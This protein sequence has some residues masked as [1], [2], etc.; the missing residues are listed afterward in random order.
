VVKEPAV[1]FVSAARAGS[2]FVDMTQKRAELCRRHDRY[3]PVSGSLYLEFPMTGESLHLLAVS[4]S[5]IV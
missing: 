3:S 4:R 5:W 2:Q 1:S